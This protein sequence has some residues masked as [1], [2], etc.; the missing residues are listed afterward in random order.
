MAEIN[1]S[2]SQLC[3]FFPVELRAD[4]C[5]SY[6]IKLKS[7]WCTGCTPLLLAQVHFIVLLILLR[8]RSRPL[9]AFSFFYISLSQKCTLSDF[10]R[11]AGRWIYCLTWSKP[12][13]TNY[14]PCCWACF[15]DPNKTIKCPVR[16]QVWFPLT[17]SPRLSQTNDCDNALCGFTRN[18]DGRR[19]AL[20]RNWLCWLWGPQMHFDTSGWW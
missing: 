19:M 13:I 3:W 5:L 7:H 9:P 15:T 4:L 18:T 20:K 17:G 12:F 11:Y 6:I 14:P 16:S 1:R 10:N 2:T 8:R